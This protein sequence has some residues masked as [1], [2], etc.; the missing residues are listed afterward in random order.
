M[1]FEGVAM[2][3]LARQ[4]QAET[5]HGGSTTPPFNLDRLRPRW[6]GAIG[7]T[8]VAGFAVAALVAP[9]STPP[10]AKV[11]EPA[12]PIPIASRTAAVPPA[13]GVEQGSL[14]ADDGVP[15]AS[16]VAKSDLDHCHHGL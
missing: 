3:Y 4:Q 2:C 6:I 15:S 9:A 8:L 5:E 7:A 1:N 11:T 16:D 12:A 13:G 14:P 10:L